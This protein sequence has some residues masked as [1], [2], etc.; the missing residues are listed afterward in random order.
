MVVMTKILDS[1]LTSRAEFYQ[2]FSFVAQGVPTTYSLP[3][4]ERSNGPL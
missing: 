1:F 2:S 4:G 3:F